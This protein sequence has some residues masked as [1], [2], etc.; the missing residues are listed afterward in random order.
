MGPASEFSKDFLIFLLDDDIS[1]EDKIPEIKEYIQKIE[2]SGK[3]TKQV[4]E[5]FVDLKNNI[6][7]FWKEWD[8]LLKRIDAE[9]IVALDKSIDDLETGMEELNRKVYK[10]INEI[11]LFTTLPNVVTIAALLPT[12]FQD[13]LYESLKSSSAAQY[14]QKE[15]Q[16]HDDI[17]KS[18]KE[19]RLE[20][21]QHAANWKASIFTQ[22]LEEGEKTESEFLVVCDKVS[23]L[24][25]VF[26]TIKADL[27]SIEEQLVNG[28]ADS[29]KAL[30]KARMNATAQIYA[31]IS[32]ALRQ[33]QVVVTL[34]K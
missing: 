13:A 34:D 2:K 23:V 6:R 20:R 28:S 26:G 33:Y 25:S 29:S 9:Y 19:E 12:L 18:L 3:T 24:T 31:T 8:V 22:V 10:T 15:I 21:E 14:L 30:F 4:S 16:A 32:K 1:P 11:K 7:I 27:Q 17:I 5:S